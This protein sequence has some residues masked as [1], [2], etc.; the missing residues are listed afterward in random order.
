MLEDKVAVSWFPI[1]GQ[2]HQLVFA[3]VDL[4]AAMIGERRV[5]QAEGV[6]EVHLV[7]KR[8]LVAGPVAERGGGPLADAVEHEDGGLLERRGEECTRRVGLVMLGED[9]ALPVKAAQAAVQY[10][11]QLELLMHP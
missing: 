4:E 10:A 6:R 11:R 9:V 8:H 5:K 2:A 7:R 3:T 1:G